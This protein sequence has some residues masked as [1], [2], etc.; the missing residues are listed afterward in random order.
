MWHSFY[1][2]S[3]NHAPTHTHSIL[4]TAVNTLADGH[5]RT[6]YNTPH[7]TLLYV[8]WA[9]YMTA[10]MDYYADVW[11]E[12]IG[13]ELGLFY[14]SWAD[15]CEREGCW[16][17]A[18]GVYMKGLMAQAQPLGELIAAYN[19]FK[20]RWAEQRRSTESGAGV[21]V[22][23]SENKKRSAG[24]AAGQQQ[25]V[26]ASTAKHAKTAAIPA[27]RSAPATSSGDERS[28]HGHLII[29]LLLTDRLLMLLHMVFPYAVSSDEPGYNP[30]VLFHN[31]IEQQFEQARARH[32]RSTHVPPPPSQPASAELAQPAAKPAKRQALR[33]MDLSPSHFQPPT[34]ASAPSP[35]SA[36]VGPSAAS[37]SESN[38]LASFFHMDATADS[39]VSNVRPSSPTMFTKAA[40]DEVD[41]MWHDT[42][43]VA[44]IL[45][46]TAS[47]ASN[48]SEA[49]GRPSYSFTSRSL[50][51]ELNQVQTRTPASTMPDYRSRPSPV[52][53]NIHEDTELIALNTRVEPQPAVSFSVYQD[54]A[55]LSPQSLAKL[56]SAGPSEQ[57]AEYDEPANSRTSVGIATPLSAA[58][59][60]NTRAATLIGLT[61]ILETSRESDASS[62]SNMSIRSSSSITTATPAAA[63]PSLRSTAV[64]AAT[65]LP[66]VPSVLI[67]DSPASPS[68]IDPFSSATRSLI[69][70]DLHFSTEP[71]VTIVQHNQPCA[72][73]V[74]ALLV[75]DGVEGG[76]MEM[77]ELFLRVEKRMKDE[78]GEEREH[79]GGLHVYGVQ[80]MD[81]GEYHVL[82]VL[83][84]QLLWS[85]YISHCLTTRLAAH[86]T[87]ASCLHLVSSSHLFSDL[88]CSLL[89]PSTDY[90]CLSSL[91]L[92][93]KRKGKV[94]GEALVHY[95]T[96]ELLHCLLL[97]SSASIVHCGL[98]AACVLIPAVSPPSVDWTADRPATWV[99]HSV[100]VGQWQS[101]VD[102]QVLGREAVD[103]RVDVKGLVRIIRAM[104]SVGGAGK[105]V[106]AA[107]VVRLEC[108]VGESEGGSVSVRHLMEVKEDVE[109]W[110]MG[111][112]GARARL[113]KRLLC[114][115]S[116]ML[117]SA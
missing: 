97:L 66:V 105:G 78:E 106:L 104:G 20:L 81:S 113:L 110:L 49:D 21:G 53:F 93:Y 77:G 103:E 71:A 32:W 88:C 9:D 99:A 31:S 16:D 2:W 108:A 63:T 40:A 117:S 41:A 18:D 24:V 62:L 98:S 34:T 54:T 38:D 56:R 55:L 47:A 35:T 87:A 46:A 7:C 37:R 25:E 100:R 17:E 72:D 82:H 28:A 27:A 84:T 42:T 8:H 79:D 5:H 58:S 114:E 22:V 6:H 30:A 14:C 85:H 59:A 3:L 64:P 29:R 67:V 43:S 83:P 69:L 92:A 10:P 1:E 111:E 61:P 33:R 74:K 90:I 65:P 57:E 102:V 19:A 101:A 70:G 80:D 50:T 44:P 89:P 86:P 112:G 26:N 91:L 96:A 94:M 51:S 115:Q 75:G 73:E 15:C 45:T 39:V 36:S 107:A 12:G 52:S 109:R 95:Y 116:V 60:G 48:A 68:A 4:D 11:Q 23:A 76:T 13:R